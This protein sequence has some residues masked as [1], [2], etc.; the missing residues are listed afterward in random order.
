MEQEPPKWTQNQLTSTAYSVQLISKI[1]SYIYNN[2]IKSTSN[3][4]RERLSVRT[5]YICYYLDIE[6]LLTDGIDLR[7]IQI[8][9]LKALYNLLKDLLK[10]WETKNNIP[11]HDPHYYAGI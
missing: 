10:D 3:I 2:H 9:K 6:E 4:E 5:N 11:H 8:Q 1:R 7:E